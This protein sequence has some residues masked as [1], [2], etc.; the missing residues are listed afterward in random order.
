MQFSGEGGLGFVGLEEIDVDVEATSRG[1]VERVYE[2]IVGFAQSGWF[3]VLE[4]FA[5]FV[6]A[7]MLC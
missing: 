1:L 5:I 7:S 6:A 3:G 4:G 2:F